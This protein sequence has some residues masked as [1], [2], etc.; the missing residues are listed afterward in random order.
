MLR[1]GIIGAGSIAGVVAEATKKTTS[2]MISAVTSRVKNNAEKFANSYGIETVFDHWQDMIGSDKIDA[3]YVATPTQVRE[4]ICVAAANAGKHVFAEKP[5]HSHRS[6]MNI[7]NAARENNVAFMD[8]T[9]FTHNPRTEHLKKTITDEIGKLKLIRST[10]YYPFDDKNNI[11]FDPAKEP[12]GSV[13]DLAW[14]NMRAIVEF[15]DSDA[16][17]A[18]IT[19]YSEKDAETGVIIRASGAMIFKDGKMSSFDFGFNAGVITMDLDLFGD[20]GLI[21]MDDFVLDWH[22]GFDFSDGYYP[23]QYFVR[24]NLDEPDSW[25]KVELKSDRPQKI[26]MIENFVSLTR[27]PDGQAAASSIQRTLQTQKLVD[28]LFSACNED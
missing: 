6:L 4:E 12:L 16:D 24:K 27:E 9:H 20:K 11:R 17:P 3:V 26:A 22:S 25:K 15:L 19:A 8:A 18:R 7:I 1:I 10:F 21:R 23:L 28:A 5:F 2:A 13:G 14:Y